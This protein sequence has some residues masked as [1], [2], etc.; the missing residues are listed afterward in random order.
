[1]SQIKAGPSSETADTSMTLHICMGFTQ[2]HPSQDFTGSHVLCNT[3]VKTSAKTSFVA[4]IK[5]KEMIAFAKC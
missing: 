2:V 3:V 5:E 1:M 4:F